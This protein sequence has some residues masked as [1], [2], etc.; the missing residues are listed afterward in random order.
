MVGQMG[1]IPN[2]AILTAHPPPT[3]TPRQQTDR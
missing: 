3:P 1:A 2:P